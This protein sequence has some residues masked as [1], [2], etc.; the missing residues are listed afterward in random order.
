M[1]KSDEPDRVDALIADWKREEPSLS[2]EA[3]QVAG[4]I[5]RLGRSYQDDV[6]AL[7]QP[8]GLSYSDFDVI[9]TLRR[10]GQPYVLTP[11]QLQQSVLLTSGAMTACLRRLELRGLISRSAD[12]ED[13]RRSA[14]KLTRKGQGLV[15]KLI[16]RRFALADRSLANLNA[17]QVEAL[18]TLLRQLDRA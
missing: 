17:R 6:S 14:A 11:T 12:A 18:T 4:R 2:A 5:I 9:A 1:K 8:H 13:G 15:D 7:L 10:C 16:A 3:M